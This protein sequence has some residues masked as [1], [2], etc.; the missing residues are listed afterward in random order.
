MKALL[1]GITAG[2]RAIVA[3][4]LGRRGHQPIVAD[5]G[6][7]ALEIV[8]RDCPPLDHRGGSAPR[9]ERGGVLSP[10]ARSLRRR[11]RRHPGHHPLRR[12]ASRGPRSGRHRSLHHLARTRRPG[13]PRADRRAPRRAARAAAGTASFASGA[14]SSRASPGSPSRTS[15]A[16]S[17]RPTTPSLRMLGYTRDEMLAGQAELG[18]HLP[19]RSP[20]PGHRR[21]R[22]APSHRLSSPPRE[23]VRPQGRATHRRP[24]RLRRAR[25]HDRVHQLRHRHLGQK[26]RRGSAARVRSA[27]PRA[28]RAVAVPQVSLRPRDAPLSRRERGRHP[29]LRL[30]ARRVPADDPRGHPAAGRRPASSRTLPRPRPATSAGSWRH[31]KKDGSVIDVEIT[32]QKFVLGGRPCGLAVALDVTERNRLEGQ[33]R[34]TQK[35][36]AIGNLAGGVAHDFNNLL[37][38]ILSYSEMLAATLK[39]ADPMRDDLARDPGRPASARRTSR[40]SSWR[41]A[42]SR[43]FSRESSI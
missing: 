41:S 5:D 42:G 27:V 17:R 2:S 18:S 25:R 37:S 35:M 40:G 14:S 39:P 23:S 11:R 38:V 21:S 12:R 20:G 29:S 16:T 1:V 34:Q 9:H 28:L 26:G 6:A 8:R 10:R 4:V 30:L 3:N 31:T 13:D 15:T 32:V 24:G 33:L 22:P 36:E 43:S 7:G 19:A